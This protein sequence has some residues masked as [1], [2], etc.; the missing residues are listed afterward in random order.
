MAKFRLLNRREIDARKAQ[1]RKRELDEG[2][3]LASRVDTLREI[4]ATEETKLDKFRHE[5]LEVI[6]KE[7][8]DKTAEK[9]A[10]E[11]ELRIKRQEREELER[12]L[13][14][15][16]AALDKRE[17]ELNERAEEIAQKDAQL[18]LSVAANIQRERDN[19][20]ERGRIADERATASRN[21][22]ESEQ[23]HT[24]AKRIM[25]EAVEK[26][27]ILSKALTLRENRVQ[28]R[29]DATTEKEKSFIDREKRLDAYENRLFL[30]E[31]NLKDSWKVLLESQ[32]EH[33]GRHD[34]KGSARKG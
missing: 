10:L 25:K 26:D 27:E 22:I 30:W 5:S 12:P 24:D 19:E 13:D 18:K 21:L 8:A 33:H 7:I 14:E 29:E 6:G 32:K 31:Q 1:E 23:L 17:A 3:K 11:R 34:T 28:K 2:K 9:D 4:A 16:K 20:V 15:K